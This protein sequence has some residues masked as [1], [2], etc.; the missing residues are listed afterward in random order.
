MGY[1]PGIGGDFCLNNGAQSF[2]QQFTG[3]VKNIRGTPQCSPTNTT[4]CGK[5]IVQGLNGIPLVGSL[6]DN[7]FWCFNLASGNM[8]PCT[9]GGGG[10]GG[11][12]NTLPAQTGDYD[13][14]GFRL[15]DVGVG[16][17]I[18]DTLEFGLNHLNDLAPATGVY[19]MNGHKIVST[20]AGTVTNDVLVYGQAG[21]F[22][23]SAN[24]TAAS[25]NR[26]LTVTAP[27]Y[28]AQG[29][30]TTDDTIA[31]QSAAYDACNTTNPPTGNPTLK[32]I[33]S[34]YLPAAPVCYKTTAPIRLPCANL[35]F[36]GE[37]H[38]SALCP[39]FGGNAI[40]Q[41]PWGD[42][43]SLSYDTSLV[44]GAG[45]S[46]ANATRA[47]LPKYIDLSHQ[48]N[49]AFLNINNL[50][51]TGFNIAFFMEPKTSFNGGDGIFQSLTAY[52][53]TGE[54][55]F[56]FKY[57]FS[58]SGNQ[59]QVQVN[60]VVSPARTVADAVLNGTTT[61][62]SATAAFVA[63]DVGR[64]V[65]GNPLIPAGTTI[66]VVGSGTSVTLSAAATGSATAQNITLSE[67]DA[68]LTVGT[69]APQTLATVYE[70]ELDWNT[71]TYQA[72]Q[73]LPGS[74]AVSCGTAA[75]THPMVQK[76][77][78]EVLLPAGGP[79]EFWPDGSTTQESAF[80]GDIDSIRVYRASVHASGYTV[81]TTKWA[82][83]ANDML[84]E[85]FPT[86][87]D[88]TQL[89]TNGYTGGANIYFPI[90]GAVPQGVGAGNIHDL[91]E[92]FGANPG[93]GKNPDGIFAAGGP[94]GRWDSLS[95]QQAGYIQHDFAQEDY[96]S[97]VSNISGF[98]GHVGNVFD[99][100]PAN[101]RED[102]AQVDGVD[103]AC[104]VW[105][106]GGGGDHEDS[107]P[108]CSDRGGL[109]YGWIENQSSGNYYYPF[110]DS[111]VGN[112]NF[113]TN[114]LL[115][116][117]NSP[118]NIIG[119]NIG[120]KNAAPWAQQDLGGFGSNFIGT[121]F[122]DFNATV[123]PPYAVAITNGTPVSPNILEAVVINNTLSTPAISNQAGDPW[124]QTI[125]NGTV[126]HP[127]L[128]LG[129]KGT[130][131]NVSWANQ[132]TVTATLTASSLAVTFQN[133][134]KNSINYLNLCQD[135]TG[136]R[137]GTTFAAGTGIPGSL[138]WASGPPP[139]L[140][141]TASQCSRLT[142][143]FDGTNL[144]GY[145]ALPAILA[146]YGNATNITFASSP[147]S[148]LST[149][150]FIG[151]NA[152]GGAV[153]VNLPAATLTKRQLIIKKMDSSANA[154]TITRAGSDLIDGATTAVDGSQYQSFSLYDGPVTATWSIF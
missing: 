122:S 37:G 153:I 32:A 152:T 34:V 72:W 92:C 26:I 73:G 118:Y 86:S 90:I 146:N 147:Y 67:I 14:H 33:E 35:E 15:T 140:P 16:T 77:M 39:N 9:G 10:G 50:L 112:S 4:Q 126:S 68:L 109:Q 60:T 69:C 106:G 17:T 36:Y 99:V 113:V 21:V 132:D 114:F 58:G 61:M 148:V 78:E 149:D 101:L 56:N 43:G 12:I 105:Q 62:T 93:Q 111:E 120:T 130:N 27:P 151:C 83:S 2:W 95:C 46:L 134:T 47:Q 124:V 79:T 20:A 51:N 138:I 100:N 94:G 6:G 87:L 128:L 135:G 108:T 22:L 102:R 49:N 11:P 141:T 116:D 98:G 127:T 48:L 28:N 137:I 29:D 143:T 82:A 64:V 18:G 96:N 40:I 52:P 24:I 121:G 91:E 41:E 23:L 103:G 25:I 54:G 1:Q 19:S 63:G 13:A 131:F 42:P 117:P 123:D 76:V 89:A 75:S 119:G 104:E 144:T 110:V 133:P 5:L 154:C 107:H 45:N 57:S 84:L 136:G 3:D 125:N 8:V 85:N 150:Y 97:H 30:G 70:I 81:P 44:T 80:L 115:N 55:A 53:A 88:G 129:G 74:P 7:Q 142:F 145:S 65:R 66:S 139:V 31:I 38:Q 59:V 71:T